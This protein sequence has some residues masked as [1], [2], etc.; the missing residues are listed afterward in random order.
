L[1]F[2]RNIQA[3]ALPHN[4]IFPN[5]DEFKLFASMTP[6]KEVGGD[7]YD[8]FLIDGNK[9]ALVIADVSG[10]GIPAALF[11]MRSRSV[12]R[13]LAETGN[14]PAEILKKANSRLCDGNDAEMFVTA[15]VGIV[16]FTTGIMTCANAGHEYPAIRRGGE[17]NYELLKDKHGFVLGGMD[18]VSYSEY[19]VEM[20]EG[21]RIFVYTDG[22]AEATNQFDEQFGTDRMLSVLS[23]HPDFDVTDTLKNLKI[24]IFDFC[25]NTEQF[26]DITMIC[27]EFI[28]KSDKK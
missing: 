9:L 2:A 26:D 11:M 27:F 1:E 14:S 6:A 4:F 17:N 13:G 23:E 24:E 22:V 12:I 5:R 28:K 16:D 20:T 25:K 7:F 10:K 21:T 18:G 3:S 8:F 19:E 15:W